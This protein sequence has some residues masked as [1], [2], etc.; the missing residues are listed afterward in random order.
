MKKMLKSLAGI[1]MMLVLVIGVVGTVFAAT[2]KQDGVEVT[3]G[4]DFTIGA[5][6]GSWIKLTEEKAAELINAAGGSVQAS[7][8]K[9]IWQH[10]ITATTLP[11]TLT[12]TA[13]GV[14]S[15]QTLYVFHDDYPPTADA[16][17]LINSAAGPTVEGNFTKLSPVA[18]VVYTPSG[19][20]GGETSPKTGETNA[21]LFIALA[22]IALGGVTAFVVAKKKA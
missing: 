1:A 4:S 11:I 7:E 14:T 2:S 6:S 3:S 10:E 20:S 16:W 19:T 17:S 13:D 22:A 18:L 5:S 15:A 8:L 9:V 12:F 21:L